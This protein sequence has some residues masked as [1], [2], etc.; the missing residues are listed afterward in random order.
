MT[1]SLVVEIQFHPIC[2]E[3]KAGRI[4]DNVFSGA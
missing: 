3:F 4:A 1:P 2:T